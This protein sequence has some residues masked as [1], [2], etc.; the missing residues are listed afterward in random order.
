MFWRAIVF[1]MAVFAWAGCSS[2]VRP[3]P[4]LGARSG[5]LNFASEERLEEHWLKHGMNPSEFSPTL[6]KD[7]YLAK[8]RVFFASR[9]AEVLLKVRD[10]GDELRFRPSTS[11]FGVL[12]SDQVIRTYFRP[13]DG[14]QYWERQ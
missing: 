6:S 4:D 7:E 3:S 14:L 12:R 9:D 1:L 2:P 5:Q 8:A 11:E 10:N 13:N